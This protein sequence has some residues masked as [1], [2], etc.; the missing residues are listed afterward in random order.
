MKHGNPILFFHI[1]SKEIETCNNSLCKISLIYD[2]TVFSPA[3]DSLFPSWDIFNQLS[4]ALG[5]NK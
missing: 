3:T 5:L 4:L 1:S 2:F